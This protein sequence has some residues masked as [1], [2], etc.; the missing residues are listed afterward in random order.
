MDYFLD[1]KGWI[2]GALLSLSGAGIIYTTYFKV[3]YKI[4]DAEMTSYFFSEKCIVLASELAFNRVYKVYDE[5][6]IDSARMHL[7]NIPLM[8]SA[9][10]D[11]VSVAM[12]G[13]QPFSYSLIE[14]VRMLREELERVPQQ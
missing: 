1:Y 3:T 13:T 9:T 14:A 8:E 7:D 4:V 10:A 2:I 11:A 5:K 6:L 12:S